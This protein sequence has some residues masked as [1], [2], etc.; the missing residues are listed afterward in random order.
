MSVCV[1]IHQMQSEFSWNL[2][3]WSFNGSYIHILNLVNIVRQRSRYVNAIHFSRNLKRNSS[4]GEIF[5]IQVTDKH[6]FYVM[7][8]GS[9]KTLRVYLI[10]IYIQL[11]ERG[12][13]ESEQ[14]GGRGGGG[15]QDEDKYE[16]KMYACPWLRLSAH[17]R[18]FD[19]NNTRAAEVGI[20]NCKSRSKIGQMHRV[21]QCVYWL[22]S[23][24]FCSLTRRDQYSH[25]PLLKLCIGR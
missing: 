20:R 21:T 2:K 12:G 15:E 18:P 11:Q 25:F 4:T 8:C 17:H 7:P 16:K 13:G 9:S 6:T 10:K 23:F 22:K 5:G 19:A 3:L 1:H 24:V 14:W